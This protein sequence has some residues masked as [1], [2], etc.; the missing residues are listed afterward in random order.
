MKLSDVVKELDCTIATGDAKMDSEIAKGYASDLLSDVIGHAEE[1]DL[2]ITLQTHQNIVAVH[3]FGRAVS[4]FWN[5]A[6]AECTMPR[7]RFPG[8]ASFSVALPVAT[9]RFLPTSFTGAAHGA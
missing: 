2:W 7:M 3:D 9:H 8:T 6:A 4:A 1:D 5:R